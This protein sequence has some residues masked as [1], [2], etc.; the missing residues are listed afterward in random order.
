MVVIETDVKMPLV[1][2]YDHCE[3]GGLFEVDKEQ[4]KR[5]HINIGYIQNDIIF[6]SLDVDNRNVRSDIQVEISA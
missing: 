6:V 2:R 4:E 5:K 3:F 1:G